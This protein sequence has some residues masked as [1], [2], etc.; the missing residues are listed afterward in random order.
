MKECTLFKQCSVVHI[1]NNVGF[2]QYSSIEYNKA[3][4]YIVVCLSV[5]KLLIHWEYLTKNGLAKTT[6]SSTSISRTYILFL[7]KLQKRQIPSKVCHM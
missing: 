4:A 3:D 5:F 1:K 2:D 6:G 7:A